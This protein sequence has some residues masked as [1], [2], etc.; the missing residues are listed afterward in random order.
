MAVKQTK[1]KKK[2][3]QSSTA[4]LCLTKQRSCVLYNVFKELTLCSEK[5]DITCRKTKKIYNNE[6]NCRFLFAD[7]R[8]QYFK[9]II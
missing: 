5:R 1:K 3:W 7:N 6:V 8:I 4:A 9:Q 2:K